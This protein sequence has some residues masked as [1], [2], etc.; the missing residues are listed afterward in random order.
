MS[1]KTFHGSELLI[2][3]IVKAEIL[4]SFLLLIT[5]FLGLIFEPPQRAQELLKVE[6]SIF[7][8]EASM[9]RI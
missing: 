4:D 5:F 1:N 3:Y 2:S 9:G 6:A 8:G 7:L